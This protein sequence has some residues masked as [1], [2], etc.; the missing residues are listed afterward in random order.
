MRSDEQ[1]LAAAGTGDLRAFEQIVRRH[2]ARACRIAYRFL[3]DQAEAEDM[4][5]EAFMRV[6]KAAPRYQPTAQFSTYLYQIVSRLCLDHRRKKRP[7]LRREM[8]D[9]QDPSPAQINGMIQQER[10][11][12]IRE[13]LDALP[14]DQR[15]A[16]VLRCYERLSYRE[17]GA[18]MKKTEKAVDR[19][20]ARARGR[21]AEKLGD[22][23]RD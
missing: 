2:Q 10:D 22:L 18:A 5:Q 8:P 7:V 9:E 15:M 16:I 13:A 20:L 3:G 17:I 6:L 11:R 19:L 12:A 14:P 21:L 4:A 1:L 23:L